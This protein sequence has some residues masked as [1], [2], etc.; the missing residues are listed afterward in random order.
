MKLTIDK[1][2]NKHYKLKKSL[3]VISIIVGVIVLIILIFGLLNYKN[4][5]SLYQ[6][7]I[8]GKNNFT[9]AQ[10]AIKEQNF[11]MMATE[12]NQAAE[13]FSTASQIMEKYSWVE[14]A[15]FAGKQFMAVNHLL[16]AGISIADGLED[17]SLLGEDIA[18]I[19]KLDG[20]E[21]T[22][23][24]I[25]KAKKRQIL[26]KLYNSPDTIKQS[27]DKLNLALFDLEQIPE[28]GLVKPLRDALAPIN[29]NLPLIKE[30]T[31][32]ALPL[33]EVL[34]SAL[35]YPDETTYLF[36]LQNN[37]ELRATGGFVGT[38][39][40]L[41]FDS[42]EISYF[43][44]DNIYNLDG[45]AEQFLFLPPQDEFAKY[46]DAKAMY[47]RDA[48]WSPDFPT[49][50]N[51]TEELY[52]L[53]NGAEQN[54]DAV[55]A[56]DPEFIL[57]LVKL[58]GAIE[59]EG[60]EYNE[61]NFIDKLQQRVEFRYQ[62]AG[63]SDAERKDIISELA[64]ILMDRILNL[65]KEKW[66]DV[67]NMINQDANEKH[68]LLSFKNEE[69]QKYITTLKWDGS[70]RDQEYTGEDFIMLVD[71][72][73]AALKTDKVMDRSI[74]YKLSKNGEDLIATL[75]ATY[76]N[77]G[78]FSNTTTRYRS[79]ARIYV[80]LG[81]E[82]ISSTGF[83]T[84][85]KLKGGT[86]T[87]ALVKQD[88]ELN[89]TVFEGFIAIEPKAQEQI[90]LTYKLPLEIKNLISNNEYQLYIQKQAG[91]LNHG[92]TIN[93]DIGQSIKEISALD[94]NAEMDNNK[95]QLS[96]DLRTDKSIKIQ[97]K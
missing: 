46:V 70:V 9:N 32:K 28:K 51:K 96:G 52:H 21:T 62:A 38:Y 31:S 2:A 14:S 85:D 42:A 33:V 19:L 4:F 53:E 95:V 69:V 35:G 1:K 13:H 44:T 61:E 58:T 60:E 39:G 3:K 74:D 86:P 23:N 72:N 88:E 36:L 73:M 27:T 66:G 16:L 90:V 43:D 57:S 18:N 26:E 94:L 34:P 7:A 68:I 47:M 75:T 15:P 37:T 64:T 77:N 24:S 55:I 49:S 25:S 22:F 63:E 5:N 54:I 41:K 29:D 89:K 67:W 20:A 10:Q 45:P 71:S 83:M 81:S 87:A 56:V 65:P 30:L 78:T 91:T 79:Y 93:F 50:A 12:L 82:L 17:L 59:I 84:N 76:Q 92:L 80:P 48:N 97:L 8:D 6:E 40:I 11:A